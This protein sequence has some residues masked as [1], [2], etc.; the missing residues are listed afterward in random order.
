MTTK[1]KITGMFWHCHHDKLCEWVYDYQERVDYIK[2]EKS[3]NEIK[4]RLRLFKK[5]KGKLPKEL[6]E[7]SK[8]Y[9][10]ARKKKDEAWEKYYEAWKKYHEAREKYMPQLIKLHKKECNCKEWNGER[11]IFKEKN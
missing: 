7:A 9:Y 2:A 5:I 10:E 6:D 3:N 11:L 1:N 8:K 4:T